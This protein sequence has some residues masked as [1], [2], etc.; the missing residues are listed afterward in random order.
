MNN[1]IIASLIISIENTTQVFF[2]STSWYRHCI[3]I[4][5]L[6]FFSFQ[7]FSSFL[8][9]K[10]LSDFLLWLSYFILL[11]FTY[12]TYLKIW[13]NIKILH[14]CIHPSIR[15]LYILIPYVVLIN[16]KDERQCIHSNPSTHTYLLSYNIQICSCKKHWQ[17]Y[18]LRIWILEHFLKIWL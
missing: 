13:F 14:I 12:F 17:L 10:Y 8:N 7:L 1:E 16:I 4:F 9:I 11:Y 18:I 5:P 3:F 15:T 2:N 6:I